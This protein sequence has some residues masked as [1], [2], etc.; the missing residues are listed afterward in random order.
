M[1]PLL[2][3]VGTTLLLI[4]VGRRRWHV[5]LRG[6]L[7]VMFTMTAT[8]HFVAYRD[9][10]I[11]MVP[12][13][14]PSPSLL[15]TVTGILEFVGALGLLHRRT[16]GWAAAGLSLLL[17]AMLPANIY[18]ALEGLTLG[19]DPVT[20]L[21]PRILQQCLYLAA[22]LAVLHTYRPLRTRHRATVG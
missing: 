19:G 7:A 1:G 8:V 3:L 20:P 16:A 9:D 18:A 21:L 10:L 11:A 6:G 2:A 4:V 14:L 15:V 13:A 17:L 5:A 12:P 22:T